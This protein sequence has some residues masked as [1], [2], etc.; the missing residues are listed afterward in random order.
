MI[1]IQATICCQNEQQIPIVSGEIL[2]AQLV[3]EVIA[4]IGPHRNFNILFEVD[5]QVG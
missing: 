4:Q 5:K 1:T 2:M 3:G